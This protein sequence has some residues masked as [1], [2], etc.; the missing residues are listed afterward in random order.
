MNAEIHGGSASIIA[1]EN[2]GASTLKIFG[3]TVTDY[4]AMQYG[5]SVEITGGTVNRMSVAATYSGTV[6]VSGKPVINNLQIAEGKKITVGTLESGAS[7]K[8]QATGVFTEDFAS[9]DAATAALAYFSATDSDNLMVKVQDKALTIAAKPVT[10]PQPTL[11]IP[12]QAALMNFSDAANLPTNCPACGLAEGVTWTALTADI[13]PAGGNQG[14]YYIPEGGLTL[15]NKHIT[16]GAANGQ[17][18]CI[19]LNGQTISGGSSSG[20]FSMR[21]ATLNLMG[22]GTVTAGD[23]SNRVFNTQAGTIN[24]YGG[25][26]SGTAANFRTVWSNGNGVF[27][28]YEGALNGTS[29]TGGTSV[30]IVYMMNGA[31]FHMEGGTVAGNR[32]YI[33]NSSAGD[34]DINVVEIAG[35]T[36]TAELQMARTV[37]VSIT[38]GTLG[39][40]TMGAD[41][42]VAVSGKP[43]ISNLTLPAGMKVTVGT[44]DTGASI[45]V[46][47]EGVFAEFENEA[48]ATAALTY[49]SAFDAEN[50]EIKAEGNALSCVDK[51]AAP[52]LTIPEQAALMNFSDAANL[53]TNC[54]A[55]GLAEGVTWTALTADIIPAG[56]NQG[57]YYIPE[58]GLTLDNKHITGGAANGQTLCI[59]LNGQ[60]IS[61]GS[62]SGIFSM[63]AATLN[64]MGSG[65]VTAGDVSNRVFNTQAGTINVYGGTYSGTAA[66]FRT[67]WSNGNGVFNLYEGALNGTSGTGGTS[68]FIVYMMNGAKFHMEGGTVAGNRIYIDNSSAGDTDINVVE[69]AGGTV[70]AELQ[71]ARTVNVSIT[72]GTLG[73]VTMGADTAV[74]VS[75]KPTISNLTLPA[76]MKVT[77]G[78]LDTG[79]SIAVNAEGVFA[80]FENEAA[81]TAALTYFSAVDQANK[82]IKA[83]GNELACENKPAQSI[84]Q[85]AAAM[86][87]SD[88]NNLPNYCPACGLTEGVVWTALPNTSG[89]QLKGHYY[90]ADETLDLGANHIT[91]GTT[92]GQT[93]C[94]NLNGNTITGGGGNGV[95]SLRTCVLNVMGDGAIIGGDNASRVFNTNSGTVNLYGGDYSAT[96]AASRV[97]WTEGTG[98]LTLH[99]GTIT[100]VAD[101]FAVYLNKG[102]TFV[103]E[104]GTVAGSRVYSDNVGNVLNTITINAGTVT[105]G[106]GTKLCTLTVAG[107]NINVLDIGEDTAATLSGKPVISAMNVA[108]GIKVTVGAL[109]TGAA[110][111]VK[112]NGVFTEDFADADAAT[113]ALAFFS[114]VDAENMEI[115]LNVKA[116]ECAAKA[117]PPVQPAD[118]YEAAILMDFSDENNLPTSCPYC[119]ETVTWQVL[120]AATEGA[121]VLEGH[122]YVKESRDA[123]TYQYSVASGK[124]LCVHLNGNEVASSFGEGVF[125]TGAN[126][127]LTIM[128]NGKVTALQGCTRA[129]QTGDGII[130]ICGGTYSGDAA[131]SAGRIVFAHGA[132]VTNLYDGE[133]KSA[134][135]NSLQMQNGATFNMYG[136]SIEGKRLYCNND[137]VVN[138]SGGTITGDGI[139]MNQ[140]TLN[141]TGGSVSRL[142]GTETT[143]AINVSGK[144]QIAKLELDEAARITVGTLESGASI[145]VATPGVI[146]EFA[147]ETAMNAAMPYFFA[148]NLNDVIKAEGTTLVCSTPTVYEVANAMNFAN[149][150]LPDYCPACGLTEGVVWQELPTVR[151]ESAIS[152][153]GHYYVKENNVENTNAYTLTGKT[154][155]HLN[156]K[157]LAAASGDHVFYV[158]GQELTVMGN[159]TVGSAESTIRPFSVSSNAT[160]NIYG[161]NYTSSGHNAVFGL[162][163]GTFKLYNGTLEKRILVRAGLNVEIYG[164]SVNVVTAESNSPENP[165][166]VKVFGGEITNYMTMNYGSAVEVTGGTINRLHIANTYEGTVTISGNPT[167]T[168]LQ[169]AEGEKITVGE[170]TEGA[171]VNVQATGVFTENFADETAAEAALAYFQPAAG[172]VVVRDNLALSCATQSAA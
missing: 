35:G 165:G 24:V 45:A 104:G 160:V 157:Q 39:K 166:T 18:L 2:D 126:R 118:V 27:N 150:S 115:K 103:M 110:I 112:A 79:A 1:C 33:D 172:L 70:T 48:A 19:H 88:A 9:E 40:V 20:I 93:L 171:A 117:A 78:T 73:K 36:V 94:V 25:T 30:F 164:G 163:T 38:G 8:V 23:V 135:T 66:N 81:A 56:G 82:M 15:D 143:V 154:C 61:G 3:G 69:I 52:V 151:G 159:G 111:A 37:N 91:V 5:A 152:L 142:V 90:V 114:A 97:V 170:M 54:P 83:E 105:G 65:T 32:I 87:F 31:K 161:G 107:G 169:L 55:C 106:V 125:Q 156:G 6:S 162:G 63:R 75:G 98:T 167:I 58:G 62:S 168:S 44:L 109:D 10:P 89:Q 13:I 116:L 158:A 64:L 85:Q 129:L 4:V 132:G 131:T 141:M 17:T 49:F 7:I 119:N 16:G 84:A 57:H 42:A 148:Y 41:T 121:Q 138:I 86:D 29:G 80:E 21:A 50:K 128:G 68:V 147:N 130:N 77:V 26:Y 153:N 51:A 146:A 133:F 102:A 28:L 12:E 136:G 99:E 123:N 53:P 137:C 95:F 120:P 145:I 124:K 122:Y 92:N 139:Y 60:T 59:H 108:D 47:A 43:T 71:M 144:A 34:T 134:S 127:E 155:L 101:G 113:A 46:N 14:H 74:A 76:G 67:V 11:T 96:K 149:A 22:S 100:G 72:G 140:G